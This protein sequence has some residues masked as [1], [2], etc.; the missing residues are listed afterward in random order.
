MYRYIIKI[1]YNIFKILY[2]SSSLLSR[3]IEYEEMIISI[4]NDIIGDK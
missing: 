3:I 2:F 1:R 4:I